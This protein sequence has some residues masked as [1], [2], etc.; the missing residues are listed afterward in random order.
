MMVFTIFGMESSSIAA[1]VSRQLRQMGNWHLATS[2][3]QKLT[4]ATIPLAGMTLKTLEKLQA[5]VEGRRLPLS[6][7]TGKEKTV[8]AFRRSP[9]AQFF[10][11]TK[12]S[13]FLQG[14]FRIS[15]N[16][17]GFRILSTLTGTLASRILL[18]RLRTAKERKRE[19]R[20]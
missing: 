6:R 15:A 11:I 20:E 5:D 13:I 9:A 14:I 17:T 1:P 10:P 2:N 19:E 3:G 12:A 4:R 18:R 16:C 7:Q 8:L